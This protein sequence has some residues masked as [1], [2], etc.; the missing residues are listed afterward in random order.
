[1]FVM[2]VASLVGGGLAGRRTVLERRGNYVV[3][4]EWSGIVEGWTGLGVLV[5]DLIEDG[6]DSGSLVEVWS[7][8]CGCVDGSL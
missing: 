8:L 5:W 7:R 1:M 4:L 3:I 6:E 2:G